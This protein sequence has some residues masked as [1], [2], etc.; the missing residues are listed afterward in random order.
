MIP[1]EDLIRSVKPGRRRQITDEGWGL[2]VRTGPFQGRSLAEVSLWST[3]KTA[4]S[5]PD[6]D[7]LQRP[8]GLSVED[9]R[10]KIRERKTGFSVVFIVDAS[11][12]MRVQG[13]MSM[14]KGLIK[15]YLKECYLR[16]DRVALVTFRHQQ[17]QLILPFTGN[18]SRAQKAL[19]QLAVGGKTPLA[20]GLRLGFRALVQERF[21]NPRAEPVIVLVSDGKPNLPLAGMD[22]VDEA[23]QMALWVGRNGIRLVFIDPEDNPLAFGYGPLIARK[24]RGVYRTLSDLIRGKGGSPPTIRRIRSEWRQNQ[25]GVT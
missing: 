25:A 18:I 3:A 2:V 8:L 7:P 17:S 4:C 12:S 14:V 10:Q 11:S 22:P 19:D 6:F 21:Q 16:R 13:R 23:F 15:A 20:E 1:L 5:R 9:L 24:A